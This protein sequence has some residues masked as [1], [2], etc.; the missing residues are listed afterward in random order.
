RP[1][2]YALSPW[3]TPATPPPEMVGRA[4]GSILRDPPGGPP[5]AVCDRRRG[6]PGGLVARA[7]GVHRRGVVGSGDEKTGQEHADRD[8]GDESGDE[9][10]HQA[11][12]LVVGAEARPIP[13]LPTSRLA[14][15][16]PAPSTTA[17]A[18]STE[19][20][21]LSELRWTRVLAHLLRHTSSPPRR[22]KTRAGRWQRGQMAGPVDI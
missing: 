9:G 15:E 18:P 3:A 17:P 4:A 1:G 12:L 6:G 20:D 10:E 16:T 7:L 5:R 13:S 2:R 22:T 8:A 21:G 14:G 11:T 19:E